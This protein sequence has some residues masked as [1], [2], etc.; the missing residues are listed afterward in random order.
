MVPSRLSSASQVAAVTTRRKYALGVAVA[1]SA[2]VVLV[3]S[4]EFWPILILPLV[5][6]VPIAGT[7]GLI[8]VSAA[9][10]LLLAMVAERPGP[11]SRELVTA[12]V[13]GLVGAVLMGVLTERAH[14]V[15]ART[16]V[17]GLGDDVAGFVPESVVWDRLG[18]AVRRGWTPALAIVT[19]D[20]QPDRSARESAQTARRAI[21]AATGALGSAQRP[22]DLV[23]RD[24]EG[25]FVV[26]IVDGQ[27]RA[28]D[29]AER[30]RAVVG[31]VEIDHASDDAA[32]LTASVGVARASETGDTPDDVVARAEAALTQARDAGGNQ[33]C[34]PAE[35]DVAARAA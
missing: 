22:S 4:L 24:A 7:E 13:T 25:R 20:A 12:Y 14:A 8:G 23:A 1:L 19:I 18:V 10:A 26:L 9:V 35:P 15:A 3:G 2:L 17:R 31:A 21:A 33:V 27:D 16:V 29:I 30:I 5:V 34:G 28:R 11:T 32:T 6:A